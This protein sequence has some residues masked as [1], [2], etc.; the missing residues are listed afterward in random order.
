[1]FGIRDNGLT[2]VGTHR[3][4]P[5]TPSY[6]K[7]IYSDPTSLPISLDMYA[8]QSYI[9]TIGMSINK[10]AIIEHHI[11]L[12][13]VVHNNQKWASIDMIREVVERFAAMSVQWADN[14]SGCRESRE[15]IIQQTNDERQV[16]YSTHHHYEFLISFA[17]SI[18]RRCFSSNVR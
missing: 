6:L 14:E 15:R 7:K 10:T 5:L 18:N 2:H 11:S 4:I 16:M 8:I 1:M 13:F 3:A 9:P 17:R 12:L